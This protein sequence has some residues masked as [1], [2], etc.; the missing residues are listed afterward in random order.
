MNHFFQFSQIFSLLKKK[1]KKCISY[2]DI[3]E[4]F[5]HWKSYSLALYHQRHIHYFSTVIVGGQIVR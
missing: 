4:N 1:K 2:Q 5:N 3:E